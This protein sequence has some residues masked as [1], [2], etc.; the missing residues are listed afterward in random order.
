MKTQYGSQCLPEAAVVNV[1]ALVL[2]RKIY[3]TF[4]DSKI[5][6]FGF[7]MRFFKK[8]VLASTNYR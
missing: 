4:Q 1:S 8:F 7:G 2:F 3:R 6:H 5:Y